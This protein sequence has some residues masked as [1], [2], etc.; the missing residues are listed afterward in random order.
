[1]LYEEDIVD[2]YKQKETKDI[3]NEIDNNRSTPTQVGT[4]TDWK[5]VYGGYHHSLAIKTDGT[6]YAWGDDYRGKLGIGIG[7]GYK[8]TPTQVGT[9]TDWAMVAC[10]YNHTLGLKTD[11]TLYS[12]GQNDDGELG[13]NDQSIHRNTPTQVGTDTDWTMVA[14]GYHHSLAI[15]TDGT[16]Y[17]WGKNDNDSNLGLNDHYDRS[18]P[19]QVGSDTDWAMV[20]CGSFHNLIFKIIS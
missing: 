13:L 14:C 16:L 19:T 2:I 12:W 1:M 6:L 18:T 10:G 15:K 11:G 9:D 4:D 5:M 17:A 3:I 7:Y 20:D 8:S